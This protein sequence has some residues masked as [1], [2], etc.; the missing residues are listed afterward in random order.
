MPGVPDMF[1]EL[2]EEEHCQVDEDRVVFNEAKG[3][4]T[5]AMQDALAC[6]YSTTSEGE[7]VGVCR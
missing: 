2:G 1:E 5:S 7:L 3:E 4:I 6:M